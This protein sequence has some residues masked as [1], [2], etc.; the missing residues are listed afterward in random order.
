[1]EKIINVNFH[2]ILKQIREFRDKYYP[3]SCDCW[4]AINDIVC[5][6]VSTYIYRGW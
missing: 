2:E 1:M 5:L 3:K 6:L 4:N